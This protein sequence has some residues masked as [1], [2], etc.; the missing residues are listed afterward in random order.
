MEINPKSEARVKNSEQS[1]E[2]NG[3]SVRLQGSKL[4]E[5]EDAPNLL[6]NNYHLP[7]VGGAGSKEMGNEAKIS[8]PR[9]T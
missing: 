8:A 7:I 2:L 5:N 6:H 1:T 4:Q 3:F 9:R